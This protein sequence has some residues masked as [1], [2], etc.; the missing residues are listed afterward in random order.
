MLKRGAEAHDW[1]DDL[2]PEARAS[3]ELGLDDIKQGRTMSSEEF[4][5][6]RGR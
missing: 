2:S 6:K 4:W 1:A 5:K 3:I